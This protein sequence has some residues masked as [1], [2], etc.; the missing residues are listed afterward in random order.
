MS[1][2]G[3]SSVITKI[4]IVAVFI[5]IYSGCAKQP[6]K[7]AVVERPDEAKQNVMMEKKA[8]AQKPVIAELQPA[9]EKPVMAEEK[10]LAEAAP[11]VEK[12]AVMEKKEETKKKFKLKNQHVVKKGE[13]LWW[14][15]KY[16]DQYNDP[17]LWPVIYK[18]NKKMI[19]D[20]N[21]IYPGQKFNIPRAGYKLDIIKKER[22]KAGA[23]KPYLPPQ[24]ANLPVN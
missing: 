13:S 12:Q 16:K 17:Y 3:W 6:S 18:A 1:R 19:K 8:E 9:P 11:V 21:L 20:A 24:D 10:Q 14:I 22:R 5:F 15:A 7:T 2:H 23:P 4:I